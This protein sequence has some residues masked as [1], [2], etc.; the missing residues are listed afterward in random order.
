[1]PALTI[2][3]RTEYRFSAPVT[4]NPHR[5]MLRPREGHDVRVLAHRVCLTPTATVTWSE[6]IFGNT[7]ATAAFG[8]M[9]ARLEIVA[10]SDVEVGSAEWPVFPIAAGA[11]SYP[12][13]YTDDELADLGALATLQNP[14]PQGDLRHWARSFVLGSRTDT[15]S[16]LKDLN[17]GIARRIRYQERDDEGTQSP[18]QSLNRGIGS[19]RDLAVLFAEAARA[20]GFGAR[21][22]SGYL[23][24][25]K[26]AAL[27]SAGSG[28]T[29]AWAQVYVPGAGWLAFDPTNERVGD[30]NL[31]AVAVA[32]G[33][34][35]VAPVSGSF[36]GERAASLG[37][38]VEV[39][40]SAGRT[41]LSSLPLVS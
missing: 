41:P 11:A 28:S 19:C 18:L 30:F 22:A 16:L 14:D 27:G 38:S 29:H 34:E 20:L 17:T 33:I 21:I 40:V 32:R 7:I 10:I 15:L 4:L 31:V 26:G 2:R 25:P 35:Q 36:A 3:H 23:Y 24:D 9:A 39:D 1:M 5:M 6:D 12:F 37:M 13:A 8:S